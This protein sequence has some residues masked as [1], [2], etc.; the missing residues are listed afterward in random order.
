METVTSR[1]ARASRVRSSSPT[2][3]I[4]SE[5]LS[6]SCASSNAFTAYIF[7]FT[8]TEFVTG[9]PSGA[10]HEM[11][12]VVAA[13]IGCVAAP[14]ESEFWLKPPFGDVSVQ[15]VTPWVFQKTDVR[16]PRGTDAGTAQ[17]STL[18]LTPEVVL[19]AAVVVTTTGFSFGLGVCWR[20]TAGA[21]GGVPTWKPRDVQRLSKNVGV[22]IFERKLVAHGRD[23]HHEP[24]RP[25]DPPLN[26]SEP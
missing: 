24:T 25:C 21:G 16:P 18:G 10:K 4:A 12:N 26:V 23:L 6:C 13:V 20:T 14:P 8:V 19:V 17:I 1:S 11:E 5:R 2:G 3:K 9:E 22:I 15:F 7:K